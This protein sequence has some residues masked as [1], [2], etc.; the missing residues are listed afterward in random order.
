SSTREVRVTQNPFSSEYDGIGFGRVELLTKPGT[1][2]F[3]GD[4]RFNFGDSVFYARN[5]F[6]AEKPDLQR[7][8]F[9]GT[10]SGPLKDK[11]SFTVQVEQRNIGQ[12]AAVNALLLDANLNPVTYRDSILNPT[13]NTE[14]SGRLDYELNQNHTLTARYQWEKN[15][16]VNAGLDSFSLPSTAYNSD[17]REHLLQFT[18]TA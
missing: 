8:I 9:E 16:E 4:A 13:T 15:T 10:F 17:E 18:E 7:R 14:I 2:E 3:H 6:A 5:P 1:A 12:T 11:A